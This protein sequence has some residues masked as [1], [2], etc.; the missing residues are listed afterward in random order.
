MTWRTALAAVVALALLPAPALAGTVAVEAGVLTYR[1][2]TGDDNNFEISYSGGNAPTYFIENGG[3][4]T[5][6]A[7][8]TQSGGSAQCEPAGITS[9]VAF[10]DEQDNIARASDLPIPL[11]VHGGPG[12]DLFQGQGTFFG[13]EGDDD[14]EGDS[15]P[16]VLTGGPGHDRITAG[17][18][19]T[20]DCQGDADDVIEPRARPKLINCPGPPTVEVTTNR[21]SVR[22]FLASKLRIAIRC[23]VVCAYRASLKVIAPFK[24]RIGAQPLSLDRAGW[25]G[26]APVWKLRAGVDPFSSTGRSLAFLRRFKLALVVDAWTGQHVGPTT[27]TVVIRVG[28]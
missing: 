19:D 20:V 27:R 1:A 14:L 18:N 4:V 23:S 12:S 11:V 26:V 5:A 3:S 25:L 21:V 24:R 16:N 13:D 22:Q 10:L 8:C 17:R 15:G 9:A 28:R 6:G 7:G 2:T